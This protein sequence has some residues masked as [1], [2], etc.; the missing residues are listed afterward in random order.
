MRDISVE[1][2]DFAKFSTYRGGQSCESSIKYTALYYNI[3][4]CSVSYDVRMA[5]IYNS[6]WKSFNMII[7]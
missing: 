2:T 7:L 3:V 1:T 4:L 5:Y 6:I